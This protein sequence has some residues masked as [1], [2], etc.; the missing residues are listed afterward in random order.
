MTADVALALLDPGTPDTWPQ[1]I[2]AVADLREQLAK[3]VTGRGEW[4]IAFN[5][6]GDPTLWTR[7]GPDDDKPQQILADYEVDR[8]ITGLFEHITAEANPVFDLA[9]VERWKKTAGR[10][11][12]VLGLRGH[13]VCSWCTGTMNWP[14]SDLTETADE[15][16]A[17]L[18]GAA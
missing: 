16:R 12:R 13:F 9:G 7:T 1:G 10:H 18:G 15:A 2:L 4:H 17:Y 3:A 5:G 11:V 14:C 8:R 6:Y